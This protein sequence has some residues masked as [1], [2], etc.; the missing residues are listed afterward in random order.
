MMGVVQ[1]VARSQ[2]LGV[3]SNEFRGATSTR[4]VSGLTPILSPAC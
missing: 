3:F 2:G 1:V 4:R